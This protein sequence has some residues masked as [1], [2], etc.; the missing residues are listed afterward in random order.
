MS[1]L[2]IDVS[3]FQGTI[4]WAKVAPQVSAAIIRLGYRG[5]GAAGTLCTDPMYERNM[6]GA[7]AAGL[8]VGVYWCSQAL[9]D[10]EALEEA[11]YC[12]DKLRGYQLTY[13]VLLDS[14]HMGPNASGR[15]DK[16]SKALRTR[17]G[18][19]W[20]RAMQDAGYIVGLYCSESWFTAG[21]EGASF[22]SE[23]F[24]IW[25]AKYSSQPPA[26][27]CDAWQFTSTARMDGI[28]TNVDQNHVYKNY[29]AVGGIADTIA[30]CKADLIQID[31]AYWTRVLIGQTVA[32]GANIQSLINK[33]HFAVFLRRQF[34][35]GKTPEETVTIAVEDIGMD[36]PDY[37]LDVIEGRREASPAN[38]KALM[39]KY[40]QALAAVT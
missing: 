27:R 34:A 13:P 30:N 33:Y 16:L 7:I 12:V 10:A 38:V 35:E 32:S 28:S 26:Y 17:F 4:D 2:V 5:Y 24:D 9:S 18:L 11:R 3:Q 29:D 14:E 20:A 22:S 36:S 1:K 25:I 6:R 21:I 8:P 23:G 19:K 31:T 15:A 37:W 40:H 39:D